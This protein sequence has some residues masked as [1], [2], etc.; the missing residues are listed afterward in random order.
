MPHFIEDQSQ[1]VILIVVK[2][3]YE[4]Y[5]DFSF[6]FFFLRKYCDFRL[7]ERTR[8]PRKKKFKEKNMGFLLV[9]I[10]LVFSM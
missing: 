2:K 8:I 5:C 7:I 6:F 10:C 9:F 4:I 3:Y 1:L